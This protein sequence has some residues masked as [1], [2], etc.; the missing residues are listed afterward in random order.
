M[1]ILAA[2]ALSIGYDEVLTTAM[3]SVQSIASM[4]ACFL[5]S[6]VSRHTSPRFS[7]LCGSLF[8][9]AFP[10]LLVPE[11]PILF[12]AIFALLTFG[13]TLVDYAIPAALLYVVPVEIAGTYNAWRMILLNGGTM[14]ATITASFLTLPT[15]FT[16]AL[17][18]QLVTGFNYFIFK[19][20]D[21]S[22]K[23]NVTK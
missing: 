17:I 7:I 1:T 3:V 8:F 13:R 9:T 10:L 22:P 2:A 15:L 23:P 12:L 19:N 21:S 20:K 5:F 11:R 6:I 14:L 4:L 18:C 16:I